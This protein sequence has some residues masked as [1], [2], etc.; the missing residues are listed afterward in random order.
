MKPPL[1]YLL[2]ACSFI[3][4]CASVSDPRISGTDS[5]W[6]AEFTAGRVK[7]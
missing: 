1:I 4:A 5:R 3:A 7:F 2:V 6:W